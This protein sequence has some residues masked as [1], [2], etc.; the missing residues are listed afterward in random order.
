MGGME[1][2]K[3]MMIA[4]RNVKGF[5][6]ATIVLAVAFTAGVRAHEVTYRGMVHVVEADRVQVQTV[7]ESGAAGETIW[8]TVSEGTKVQRGDEVVDYAEAA[9]AEH[10]RIVVIVDHDE[11]PNAAIE[12]RLAAR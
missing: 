7:T 8:F 10:E 6:A 2:E 5:V 9:I 11:A 1:V 3:V 4:G 12:L